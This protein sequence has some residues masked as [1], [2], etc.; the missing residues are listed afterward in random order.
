[1]KPLS[2]EMA[3]L[4]GIQNEIQAVCSGPQNLQVPIVLRA[5][6]SAK[7]LQVPAPVLTHSLSRIRNTHLCFGTFFEIIHHVTFQKKLKPFITAA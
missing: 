7:E 5:S 4:L 6:K 3:C 2:V 1:M